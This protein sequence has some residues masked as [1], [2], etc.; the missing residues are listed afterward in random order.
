VTF[1]IDANGIVNVHAKDKATGKEHTIR[2]QASGGLSDDDIK[3]MVR[4]A[5]SHAAED[6]KKREQVEARNQADSLIYMT[7]KNL[8]EHGSK[9]PEADRKAIEGDVAALRT[10]ME[11]GDIEAIKSKT[12]AL[13]R[14]AMKLGEIMYKAQQEAEAG[15]G[16]DAGAGGEAK[17]GG[18]DPG[19]VD[20]DFEEVKEDRKDKTG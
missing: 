17:P 12:E 7:E 2:I 15:P 20:A 8:K 10:A 4:E 16:P 5:E 14:S 13:S 3:R 11:G 1:D 9:V 19:V 6:K 18:G